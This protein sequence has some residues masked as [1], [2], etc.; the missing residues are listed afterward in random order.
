MLGVTC[1]LYLALLALLVLPHSRGATL[2]RDQAFIG[3]T[4]RSGMLDTACAFVSW[5]RIKDHADWKLH[6]FNCC[7]TAQG[8][9]RCP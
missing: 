6:R 1:C 8:S 3:Y 7:A 5:C 4:E 2:R 9:T